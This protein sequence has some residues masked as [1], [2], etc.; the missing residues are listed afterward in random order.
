MTLNLVFIIQT[1]KQ[2]QSITVT[3]TNAGN[4]KAYLYSSELII[5]EHRITTK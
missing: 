4:S 5:A 3:K 2:K 1:F